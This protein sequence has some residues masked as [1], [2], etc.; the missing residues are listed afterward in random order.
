MQSLN[1]MQMKYALH[2]KFIVIFHDQKSLSLNFRS[3]RLQMFFK[4]DVLQNLAMF[5]GKHMCW[6]Y[7][8]IKLQGWRT[9]LVLKRDSNASAFL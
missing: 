6:S 2:N 7:F 8:L 3:S 4:I 9:G 1:K 5:A